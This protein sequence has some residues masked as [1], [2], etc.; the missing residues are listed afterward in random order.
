MKCDIEGNV[1]CTGPGGIW[2]M[3]PQGKHIG[4]ILNAERPINMN[5]GDDDWKTL[6]FG[7]LHSINRIR[8]DIP[9]IPVPRGKV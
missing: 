7:G 9:G 6:Y 2:V 4:T 1:Y 8:L 3:N 5:W